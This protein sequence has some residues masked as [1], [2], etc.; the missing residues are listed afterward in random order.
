[1]YTVATVCDLIVAKAKP[2]AFLTVYPTKK[3][4]CRCF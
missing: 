2:V 4:N 1:M 3:C